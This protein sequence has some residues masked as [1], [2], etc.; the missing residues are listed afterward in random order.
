MIRP[1]GWRPRLARLAGRSTLDRLV[2]TA[3]LAAL[4]LTAGSWL[5][6]EVWLL[7]LLTHFRMQF[8]VGALA[9][10]ILAGILRRPGCVLVALL[11]A[12]ANAWPLLP[13]LVP[14]AIGGIDAQAAQF[15]TRILFA[16]VR[17]GNHHYDA[18]RALIAEEQPDIVGLAEVDEA[19]LDGLSALHAEYPYSVL[20]PQHDAHGLALFSRLP[21]HEL[22]TS[23]YVEDGI[24]TAI[25]VEVEMPLEQATLT[26]AHPMS[27]VTPGKATRRNVQLRKIATLIEGDRNEEQILI[28]DLNI[29]PWSPFYAPLEDGATLFNAAVGRGY[30][31]TWP[32]WT[33]GFSVLQIP[34]DHCLLSDGFQV[35]QYRIGAGIGS[36]H[37]PL[38]VDIAK[39]D[40][41]T[42]SSSPSP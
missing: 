12:A 23:P 28:G 19:W 37:L 6:S 17:V 26:L 1:L 18:L 10:S 27:P 29:T 36:D 41:V 16:N 34:I 32:T 42:V 9:L 24:Q 5:G 21:I 35:Q 4:L 39:D 22:E 3:A 13:Y 40:A 8:L 11:V 20:R 38:V 7:E 15:S 2:R 25:M 14:A 31:P 30:W 33:M